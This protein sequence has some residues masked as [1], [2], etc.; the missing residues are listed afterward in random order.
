MDITACHANGCP[1]DLKK[2]RAAPDFDFV[3]D[4]VGIMHH[5][6]RRDGKLV[7]FFLPRCSKPESEVAK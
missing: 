5:I 6:D 1:L 2:L 7:N 3:H 4:V